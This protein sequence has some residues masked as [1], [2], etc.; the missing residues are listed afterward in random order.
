V[1]F[2][3]DSAPD[4]L[5]LVGAT[6]AFDGAQNSGYVAKLNVAGNGLVFSTY[7]NLGEASF[8]T[9]R[10]LDVSP[11]GEV[12]ITG[13][14][15]DNNTL[16]V[17]TGISG[18]SCSMNASVSE[19]TDG[20]VALFS[21]NG[22][23]AFSSCL[24][25]DLADG[26][27]TE[28]LRG[29][30]F[31]DNGHLYVV[32][33]SAMTDFPVVNPVQ[34][35]KNVSGDREMTISQIDPLTGSLVFSTWFGTTSSGHP[36]RSGQ[37]YDSFS[38][39]S[40]LFPSDIEVDSNG[41]IIVTGTVASL[42]YPTVNA[43][44]PNMAVPRQ[45]AEFLDPYYESVGAVDDIFV[46]KL[47]PVS[48]VEFST[49]L[50]GS[51]A[52]SCIPVLALD[53]DDN[54][55]IA[56]VTSADDY[57][58]LNAIQA[59]KPGRSSVVLSKIAPSG[60][61]AFSTY[62]G[63]SSAAIQSPGGLAVNTEGKIILGGRA[64]TDDFPVVGS[65]TS[66]N[67]GYDITLA[68]IDQ[69]GDADT[70]GDGVPDAVDDFPADDNEWRDTDDDLTGDNA[71]TDDDGDGEPDVSDRFPQD[72]SE[73]TDADED[74]A[75][76]NRDEFDADL[77]N[78]FDM[79]N[80]G[81][82]DFDATELDRDGDGTDNPDDA[83]DFDASETIDSDRD[84]VGDNADED[85]DGDLTP[86]AQDPDPLDFDVPL[87]T[88]ER[89]NA[90]DTNLFK[91][92]WPA[93]FLDVDVTDAAWT[94]AE[95]QSYSGDISFSSRLIDHGQVAAIQHTDTYSGGYV[96]FWYKVDSQENFD[97]FRFSMDSTV[98]LTN[99]GDTG[100]QLFKTSISPGNHTL[101][102]SYE[103]DGSLT[104]GADAAWIDDFES[105]ATCKVNAAS[106]VTEYSNASHEACETLLVGP[107]F[108]AANGSSVSISS[109]LE[110]DFLPGFLVEQGATLNANVCG[111]SLCATSTS[112]MPDGCHS[113][114]SQ[115]CDIDPACC[116]TGFDQA[117]LDKVDT[118]C[119]LVCE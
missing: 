30:A 52:E 37:D 25:G 58:V 92:P 103:K 17:V 28:Q 119:N 88:F 85:D 78:Y 87:Y 27:S 16:P 101:E 1:A 24:G 31:G 109:G 11:G 39:F 74:G 10:G 51:R 64:D 63:G 36:P 12:A 14:V 41:S 98:F 54:I 96:Q 72:S 66:L 43:I 13:M 32:G 70:D 100:W 107:S 77:A 104:S 2:G 23:L 79:D 112:P 90:W 18:Q 86:D 108:I 73:T 97:L 57:P 91:S 29:V 82:A 48:G 6:Q 105:V 116:D 80:D 19:R 94:S 76:D 61:L 46:T 47:N 9:V 40:Y 62:L 45:S 3:L 21:P 22:T 26:S 115:I 44:Q 60:A 113:C 38:T 110:I 111:Q 75:G 89:Y 55:Y 49:Y 99:S 34:A 50:G 33:Y 102:W 35:T 5:P 7:M 53:A 118:V 15:G 65:G 95:D 20:Y 117:C 68:I 71:D 69:S 114:V 83:F 42:N 106:D 93:G 4:G 84:G 67:G 8:A 56:G 59:S 81:L